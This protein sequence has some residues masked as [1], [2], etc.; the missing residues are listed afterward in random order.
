M[1]SIR[2]AASVTS[3]KRQFSVTMVFSP[4]FSEESHANY[5]SPHFQ[6]GYVAG[7]HSHAL[8]TF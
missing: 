7:M 1:I 5:R 8:P 4:E 3:A 2:S 6:R